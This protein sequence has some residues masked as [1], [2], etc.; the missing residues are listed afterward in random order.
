MRFLG[1]VLMAAASSVGLAAALQAPQGSFAASGEPF[2]APSMSHPF[3]T[4]DLGRDVR[5]GVLLGARRSLSVGLGTAALA[6]LLGASLG[7]ASGYAG[8][9]L[10]GALT[11][12]T[13]IFQVL[14]RFFVA[15]AVLTL[16]D[17][18]AGLL[19]L[20]LGLTSWTG[21]ARIARAE[22]LAL[23]ER[24]FVLS[25]R[26]AGASFLEVMRRHLVPNLTKP[27]LA[28][29]PLTAAQAMLTEAGLSFL[30][31]GN[32]A[33]VSW[34]YLLQNAQ[35]FLRDA[36]WMAVFPGLAMTGTILFL[37]LFSLFGGS[38]REIRFRKALSSGTSFQ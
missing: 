6:L 5:E 21:L 25:A 9:N 3:G 14:P 18:R 13:E 32:S 10:D 33:A 26:A 19:I 8:G 27:L 34:G 38:D 2:E 31:V 7:V 17:G 37:S 23:R 12:L 24:E 16:W 28:A 29:I 30:G 11:R 36:W 22:A 1:I 15:L 20:V 4:D 35:P